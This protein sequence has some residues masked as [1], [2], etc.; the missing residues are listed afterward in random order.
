MA[1]CDVKTRLL[2]FVD[3][4]AQPHGYERSF[5]LTNG[6]IWQDRFLVT[7]HV[8]AF[9]NSGQQKLEALASALRMPRALVEETIAEEFS[10]IEIVHIGY[11]KL[12]GKA[13]CKIYFE[14]AIDI[15]KNAKQLVH[16]AIKWDVESPNKN[17]VTE[18]FLLPNLSRKTMLGLIAR[19]FDGSFSHPLVD[20][21]AR[22]LDLVCTRVSINELFFLDVEEKGNPRKSFDLRLYDAGLTVGQTN[23][24]IESA[25]KLV[26]APMQALKTLLEEDFDQQL[27]HMSA[28]IGRDGYEFVSFYFG[29]ESR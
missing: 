5:K 29:V 13:L 10:G 11:E 15:E 7:L 16:R 26:K 17:V 22:L 28:G 4:L 23:S 20:W 27:G 6:H 12:N 24:L 2:G 1:D 9:D 14:K 19:N 25:A 8:D 18:Y 3:Q 21:A